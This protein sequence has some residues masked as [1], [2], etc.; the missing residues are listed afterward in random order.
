MTIL[1]F[2]SANRRW[3]AAGALLT[4][5]SSFG[6]TYFISIFAGRIMEEFALS[7]GEWGAL[8]FTGTLTSGLLMIWAGGLA[9]RFRART[10]AVLVMLAL[11]VTCLIMAANRSAWVLVVIIFALRFTG[12]GML[13]H[14]AV[15][16]MARWYVAAR[17]KA[18]AIAGL[19]FAAGEASLPLV[20]VAALGVVDWRWLWVL[21]AGVTLLATPLLIWLLSRE[22]T[23][24]TEFAAAHATGMNGLHW[25]RA[26]TIRDWR[27]WG[28]IPLA[29]VSSIFGTALFFQ[30]VHLAEVKGWNHV[31]LVALFPVFTGT[32]VVSGL[33]FG[34]LL[35]RV[36]AVR[37][38]A[39]MPLPMA[40][41]F[42]VLSLGDTIAG[43][44]LAFFLIGLAQG[45]NATTG[46]AFWAEAYGTAHVGAIKA[47]ATALMVIGSA[48]GPALTGAL[49]DAGVT[50]PEQMLGIAAYMVIVSGWSGWVTRSVAVDLPTTAPH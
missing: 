12:Q 10:L 23:P 34:A 24:G 48:I 39:W 44:G 30:Q 36:G 47:L 4:F 37:L 28:L 14:I 26:R 40:A 7:H 29:T 18:I 11:M 9:D 22:R 35:D 6:Q 42:A 38:W 5:I 50:F 45:G 8:Y 41:G 25:T 1:S 2:L 32:A 46:A 17:G 21:V 49:I 31:Q 27:F 43:A 33:V 15:V 3:L 13:S 16:A 19:G 20:F